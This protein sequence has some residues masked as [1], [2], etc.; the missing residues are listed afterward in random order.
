MSELYIKKKVFSLGGHFTVQ[1][2]NQQD[3]YFVKGSFI[4]I[5]KTFIVTDVRGAEVATITKK[6]FSWL[7][8]FFIDVSNQEQLAIVKELTFMKARYRIEGQGLIVKGDW[9]NKNFE[10]YQGANKLATVNERWFTWGDTYEVVIEDEELE[11]T[12][13]SLVVAINF[14]KQQE[15]QSRHTSANNL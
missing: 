14:V 3:K 13:I 6:V 4:S 5:P 12:I 1:D 15:E 10:V 2:Q 7:P 11:H 8:K 9:L